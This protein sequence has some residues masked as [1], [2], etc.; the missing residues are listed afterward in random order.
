M[1]TAFLELLSGL[2]LV[3]EKIAASNPAVYRSRDWELEN[4]VALALLMVSWV[5]RLRET[6][7]P[8][9][10]TDSSGFD[11]DRAKQVAELYKQW[12]SV[13]EPIISTMRIAEQSGRKTERRRRIEGPLSRC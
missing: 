10:K 11:W 6:W 4:I 5:D 7:F 2:P 8:K 13:V 9:D 12:L 3:F 1:A